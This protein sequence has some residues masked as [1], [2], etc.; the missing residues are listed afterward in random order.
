MRSD[1]RSPEDAAKPVFA[2]GLYKIG[3]VAALLAALVFRRNWSAEYS[4]L[5][6]LGVISQGPTAVPTNA[7][8]WFVVLQNHPLIGLI[9]FNLFDLVN[10][11]L[12]GLI[13]LALCAALRRAGR[14]A[15]ALAATCTMVGVA[16]A[17]ASNQALAMLSLSQRHALATSEPEQMMLQGAGEALLA[18]DSP[19]G[20]FPGAGTAIALFLVTLAS[21]I[22]AGLMLRSG[23]FRA[24]TGYV[25]LVAEGL[26]M[27]YFLALAVAP[28]LLALPPSLAAPFRLA[29]YVLVGRRL[30]QLAKE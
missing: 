25:G 30:L 14:G 29:W 13:L 12:L 11:A 1:T 18:I 28:G 22:L 9:L 27:T 8:D 24:T 10:Y 17:F 3:G 20:P 2:P 4:L 5:R 23:V 16:V 21:L 7:G 26:Q 6:T 15:A 19:A